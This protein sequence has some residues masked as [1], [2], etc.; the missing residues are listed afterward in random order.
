MVQVIHFLV[1]SRI[2]A[3]GSEA[4]LRDSGHCVGMM[5][6]VLVSP[7]ERHSLTRLHPEPSN[8]LAEDWISTS[9][10]PSSNFQNQILNLVVLHIL[11]HGIGW[12]GIELPLLLKTG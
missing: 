10:Q 6:D 2:L 7:G 11:S 12:Q 1:R 3:A 9:L 8:Q 4:R 5:T